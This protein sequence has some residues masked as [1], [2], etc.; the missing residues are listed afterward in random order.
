MKATRWTFATAGTDFTEVPSMFD[1]DQY[2]FRDGM[3]KTVMGF[4]TDLHKIPTLLLWL[5]CC[6]AVNEYFGKPG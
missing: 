4:P 2:F 1:Q 3:V 5:G 6:Q